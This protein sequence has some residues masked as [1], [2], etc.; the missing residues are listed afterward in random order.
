[1]NYILLHKD[2]PVAKIVFSDANIFDSVA[3]FYNRDLMPP[4]TRSDDSLI[5]GRFRT[6]IEQR[7]LPPVRSH[8]TVLLKTLNCIKVEQLFQYCHGLSLNDC[9]WLKPES[10]L[11]LK[12]FFDDIN[13]F[14]NPDNGF[15][16][17]ILMTGKSGSI[18]PN[19]LSPDF[20]LTGNN[21]KTW[22]YENDGIYLYKCGRKEFDY[23]DV[24]NEV[25]S[26]HIAKSLKLNHVE[27][28]IT[29]FEEKRI[30][31]KSKC[32][33]DINTEFFPFSLLSTDKGFVGKKGIMDFIKNNNLKRD[34]DKILVLDFLM[35]V[36][37]RDFTNIG[38]LR[39]SNT[40]EVKGLAPV[41]D[42][43]YSLWCDYRKNPIGSIDEAK[44]FDSSHERQIDIVDNFDFVDFDF[45]KTIP[46]LISS[47]YR[48]FN[49]SVDVQNQICDEYM[50]NLKKLGKIISSKADKSRINNVAVSGDIELSTTTSGGF[51]F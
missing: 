49:I 6:W 9:Y 41:F 44:T 34:L 33:C 45:L 10:K 8:R 40:F 38:F 42:N 12:P 7:F 2:T 39:D 13:L 24:A 35:S 5:N 31:S 19:V 36:V 18:K 37:D 15:V 48:N 1:M 51:G 4:G 46:V 30:F 47:I 21:D 43:G 26:S 28:E 27:Y 32:F 17:S 20:T 3:G 29:D 23:L 14:E 16:S 22:K 50:K 25:I 11:D